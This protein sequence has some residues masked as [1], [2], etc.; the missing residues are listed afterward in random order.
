M[1]SELRKQRRRQATLARRNVFIE[2]PKTESFFEKMSEQERE[3]FFA[4]ERIRSAR[5]LK[6]RGLK[7]RRAS[8]KGA[9][10]GGR[11]VWEDKRQSNGRKKWRPDS[12][13]QERCY[14]CCG[15]G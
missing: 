14:G 8:G 7:K 5:A 9:R 15:Q 13:V 3:S 1:D 6:I 11:G 4:K 12:E 2:T 10:G